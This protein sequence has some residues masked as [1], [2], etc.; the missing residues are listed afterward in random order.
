MLGYI[1]IRRYIVYL[2]VARVLG[3]VCTCVGKFSYVSI[4]NTPVTIH[5]TPNGQQCVVGSILYGRPIDYFSFQPVLRDWCNKDRGMCHPV[6][7][8]M[9][10]KLLLLSN[11]KSS[12]CSGC[13]GFPLSLSELFFTICPTP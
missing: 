13:G 12:T 6:C 5:L 10:I 8:M 9:H 1:N 2:C 3:C 11:K 7:W 4:C